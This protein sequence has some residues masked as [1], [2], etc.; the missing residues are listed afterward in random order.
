MKMF[1]I[2]R[3]RGRTGKEKGEESMNP[4]G[5]NRVGKDEEKLNLSREEKEEVEEVM[6]RRKLLVTV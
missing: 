6:D 4:R 5:W 2:P 1:R 3:E